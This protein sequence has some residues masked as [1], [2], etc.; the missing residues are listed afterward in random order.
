MNK[1]AVGIFYLCDGEQCGGICN[2]E[3]SHTTNI[4]HALHKDNLS[5]CLFR[6]VVDEGDNIMSF[7]E[8]ESED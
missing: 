5:E 1:V 7:I 2:T 8:K 6:P 3:C 4:K